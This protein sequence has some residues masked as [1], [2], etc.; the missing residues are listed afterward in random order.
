MKYVSALHFNT[1]RGRR[2]CK[3]QVSI[4]KNSDVVLTGL[5]GNG[6]S[7]AA[8]LHDM[9]RWHQWGG[10]FRRGFWRQ[11]AQRYVHYQ[12]ESHHTL[13]RTE[14]DG[15]CPRDHVHTHTWEQ[16]NRHRHGCWPERRRTAAPEPCPLDRDSLLASALSGQPADAHYW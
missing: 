16:W 9:T 8:I 4:E 1:H 7:T 6:Q 12:W 11:V 10:G 14:A 5:Q 3:I 2:L 15:R 13:G